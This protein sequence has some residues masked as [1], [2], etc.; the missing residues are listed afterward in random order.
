MFF[1][2]QCTCISHFTATVHACQVISRQVLCDN[3]EN[4]YYRQ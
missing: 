3:I 4:S 1:G 2:T